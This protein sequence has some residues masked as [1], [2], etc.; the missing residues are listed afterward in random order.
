LPL[1][2]DIKNGSSHSLLQEILKKEKKAKIITGNLF[3]MKLTCFVDIGKSV[4]PWSL[5][6]HSPEV[7]GS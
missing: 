1:I 4:K 5:F 7:K 3:I 6:T 2:N